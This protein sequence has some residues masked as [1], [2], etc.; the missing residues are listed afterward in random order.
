LL[1]GIILA[2]ALIAG[3]AAGPNPSAGVPNDEDRVYGFWRGLRHGIIALITFI[4]SLFVDSV[5]FYEVHNDGG[6]YNLGFVLDAGILG[7]GSGAAASVLGNPESD[8]GDGTSAA[9]FSSRIGTA[10][11]QG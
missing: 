9:G 11:N 1:I 2:L 4:I 5:H 6:W 10:W 7:G 8:P 3:C